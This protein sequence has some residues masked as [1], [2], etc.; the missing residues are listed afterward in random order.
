MSKIQNKFFTS[1]MATSESKT[2]NL[3]A[4]RRRRQRLQNYLLIWID[5]NIDQDSEGCRK[6][7]AQLRSVVNDVV[8]FTKQAECIQS[9]NE[10]VEETVFVIISGAL[11]QHLVPEI[12]ELARVDAIYIF[13]GNKRQHEHWAKKWRKIK[14]I[15]T[16]IS[17]I[18]QGLQIAVKQCNQNLMSVSVVGVNEGSSN[19][20]LNQL[21]PNFMYSQVFKE[22][23]FEIKYD[24][25]AMKVL[26]NFCR[27]LYSDNA[28][29]L[30][31]IDEFERTYRPPLAI[32]WYTRECFTYQM[33]NRAL[34]M[35]D[36]D[37]MLKMGFFLCD[38]HRQIQDLH[39]KQFI[40]N[41]RKSF[42]VYRGQG[43]S[44]VDFEKL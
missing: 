28:S 9:L 30:S 36:S 23:L 42:I 27:P 8:I 1:I 3:N 41:R 39:Q 40:E 16:D 31:I 6:T 20:T 35:L 34:R 2:I 5:N 10:I 14:G 38:L 29:E 13:C 26:V 4:I 18:C 12:H 37:T 25:E 15:H 22:I 24:Q 21:E 43:L 32:W 7:L 17:P 11:G 33:L 19:E 44:T